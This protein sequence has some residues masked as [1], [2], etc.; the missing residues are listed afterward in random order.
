MNYEYWRLNNKKRK[1]T[2]SCD[3]SLSGDP[4]EI[5][6]IISQCEWGIRIVLLAKN[7]PP[8]CFLN[9]Q[10][11]ASS[12]LRPFGQKENS[13]TLC[14]CSFLVIHRRFELRTPWLKVKC[15]ADWANGP[16]LILK[17]MAGLTGLEPAKMPESKSGALPTW[18]QPSI[19]CGVGSR[20]R[21]DDLQNHNLAL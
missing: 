13:H 9:A 8:D 18:L 15:S 10:T 21:T 11:L 4:P 16:Y 1:A 12:N 3:F 17:K 7:S 6:I 14:D 20:I 5:R 2:L 19:N